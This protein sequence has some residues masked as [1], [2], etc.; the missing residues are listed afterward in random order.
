MEEEKIR[1]IIKDTRKGIRYIL[2]ANRKLTREEMLYHI[3]IYNF[4]SLNIKQKQ[5]TEVLINV[6]D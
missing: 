1:N 2:L 5:G 3:R 6:D 4:N